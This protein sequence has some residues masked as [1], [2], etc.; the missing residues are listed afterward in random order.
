MKMRL[1]NRA[2][3]KSSMI[4]VDCGKGGGTLV[5][6]PRGYV[7]AVKGNLAPS[8][9]AAPVGQLAARMGLWIPPGG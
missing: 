3:K 2:G 5:K 4:C 1:R 9:K 8:Q 6:T 7:H